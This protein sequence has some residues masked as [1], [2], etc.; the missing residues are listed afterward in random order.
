ML[1]LGL[2]SAAA[3][4]GHSGPH[5]FTPFEDHVLPAWLARFTVDFNAG[6]FSYDPQ[7][8]A[9]PELYG[10]VDVIHVL[11]SVGALD[12]HLTEAMRDAWK[13]Q[14]DAHQTLAGGFYSYLSKNSKYHAMG[15]ATASL[16]LLRRQPLHNNSA[17]EAFASPPNGPAQWQKWYDE[18]YF[19]NGTDAFPNK[20]GCGTSIH[21]C[22]QVIGS[23]PATL[24]YTTGGAHSTFIKWWSSWLASRTNATT[25]TLLPLF[26]KPQDFLDS[27]GGGMATHGIQ[28]GIA[29]DAAL[30][31]FEL[32]RPRALFDF[33]LGLQNKSSGVWLEPKEYEPPPQGKGEQY[34]ATSRD[35]PLGSISLDGI[36]QVVRSMEQLVRHDASLNAS[37]F[38]AAESA[39]DLL[40]ATSA[41]QLKDKSHT[42]R[43]YGGNS[44]GLANVIATV[45]ECARAFP[46]LVTT[47]RKW[48]CCARYV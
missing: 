48:S 40:L 21:G 20:T 9:A 16:A 7:P 11:A 44:H 13:A 39:C 25:G 15:E 18:L 37:L 8:G 27:L 2:L 36:F 35:A 10:S 17:Y 33:A 1:P 46:H 3:A 42:L 38:P 43:K 12:A 24:A 29:Q 31:P 41:E 19:N 26:S 14:I 45:G 23:I 4:F 32:A 28:L 30:Y 22:G 34:P 47:R 6:S 5:D